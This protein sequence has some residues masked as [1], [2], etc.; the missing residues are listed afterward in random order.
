MQR[1]KSCWPSRV[2]LLDAS[3]SLYL[4]HWC[5][6]WFHGSFP[7]LPTDEPLRRRMP[8]EAMFIQDQLKVVKCLFPQLCPN[9]LPIL[10]LFLKLPALVFCCC[11]NR[12]TQTWLPKIPLICYLTV[13]LGQESGR[14]W[15]PA[16][17]FR[18]RNQRGGRAVFPSGVSGDELIWIVGSINPMWL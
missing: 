5:I 14:S 8:S 12:W 10:V 2:R 6:H 3:V 1:W 17:G 16:P 7:V 18:G 15:V 11:H 9:A 13:S 4:Q